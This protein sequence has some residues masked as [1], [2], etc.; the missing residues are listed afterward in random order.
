MCVV[1]FL[2]SVQFISWKTL[3]FLS[4]DASALSSITLILLLLPYLLTYVFCWCFKQFVIPVLGDTFSLISTDPKIVGSYTHIVQTKSKMCSHLW[5][6]MMLTTWRWTDH[7]WLSLKLLSP[8]APFS[9]QN[10]SNVVWRRAPPEPLGTWELR[11]PP[12][13]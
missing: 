7:N 2:Y 6:N 13:F 8:E 3:Y 12:Y 4:C 11:A 9:A 10:A 5:E 1:Q